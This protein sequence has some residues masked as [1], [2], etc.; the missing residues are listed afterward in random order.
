VTFVLLGLLRLVRL[1]AAE[2][3]LRGVFDFIPNLIFPLALLFF[4]RGAIRL[5][6]LAFDRLADGRLRLA[7]FPQ[8]CAQPTPGRRGIRTGRRWL[9]CPGR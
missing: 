4:T 8:E 2:Q 5:R 3:I 9:R 7:G 1:A 6:S